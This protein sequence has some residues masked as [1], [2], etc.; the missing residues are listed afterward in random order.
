MSGQTNLE[1]GQAISHYRIL[2]RIPGGGMAVV[3]THRDLPVKPT[4]TLAL[5]P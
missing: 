4:M 3:A 5:G 2:G 1:T